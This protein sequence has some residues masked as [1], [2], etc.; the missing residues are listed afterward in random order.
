MSTVLMTSLS[1]SNADCFHALSVPFRSMACGIVMVWLAVATG[2]VR[3]ETEST[4]NLSHRFDARIRPLLDRYCV[5]CHSGHTPEG[6]LDLTAFGAIATLPQDV[7]IWQTI[8]QQ[9][10]EREMPPEDPQPSDPERSEL[11]TWIHDALAAIDW[12]GETGVTHVT[13]PRLSKAEY[14]NTVRDLLGLELHPERFLLDDSPGLSGFTNDRDGLFIPP[15]LAEQYFQAARYCFAAVGAVSAP[16]V[17]C[18][19]EAE[20]MLMTERSVRPSTLPDG[21]SGYVLK[22][23][24][25]QTLYDEFDAP[26]DGWYRF[27]FRGL[28]VGGETGLRLRI[29]NDPRA[30]FVL[31]ADEPREY[32]AEVLLRAGTHQ[33]TW[34]I[35][36]PPRLKA[37]ARAADQRARKRP[38]AAG[39]GPPLPDDAADQVATA[40]R[41]NAPQFP[42]PADAS[43]AVVVLIG[44]LNAALRSMQMRIEYMRLV[45]PDGDPKMLRGYFN[46]LPERTAAMAAIKADLAAAL[47]VDDDEIDRRLIAASGGLLEGNQEL[48]ARVLPAI[49]GVHDPAFLL[50]HK[51]ARFHS[52]PGSP[53][54]DWIAIDGPILP[55]EADTDRVLQLLEGQPDEVLG[56]FLPRAFR[57]PLRS[58]E[59]DRYAAI[60]QQAIDT[61][62]TG[63][64][65]AAVACSAALCSP[66]FLFRD[67]L[68]PRGDGS[69]LDDHQLA[70]RLSYFLWLSMPDAELV[71]L[72]D[73]GRLQDDAELR[74]QVRR[75]LAD[76][77]SRAFT[78]AFIE[79]WLGISGLGT[80]HV[81]DM[82]RFPEFTTAL[83]AAAKQEP[84]L[85]FEDMLRGR[86]SLRDFLDGRETFVN[87]D[88]AALYGIPAIHGD[89]LQRVSLIDDTRGGLL[90]MVAVLTASSTPNRTSPVLRGKWVLENLL[91]RHL[92]EPPADA[93]QLNDKAGSRGKTLREELAAHRRNASCAA[94]HDRIDPIGFGLEIFDAIGRYRAEEADRPVDTTGRLPGGADFSGP[95]EMRRLLADRHADEFV[96][97][98]IRRLAAFALGRA[99]EPEDEGL[100]LRLTAALQEAGY[101]ADKLVEELVLSEAF[102]SQPVAATAAISSP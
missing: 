16:P 70:S 55:H 17:S 51:P 74:R 13:L 6:D 45:T 23:Q 72:A 81:P 62:R 4:V 80:E 71:E 5:D 67:E 46:L 48:L 99:L 47:N 59:L 58:G 83:A 37:A 20:A 84:V 8:L 78:T 14:G 94:C 28:G 27:T 73:A 87:A 35:E 24:G 102:R 11:V 52:Q 92:A 64:E 96:T 53:G 29:D 19:H 33:M 42:V 82:R 100:V 39:Q 97:N 89:A 63:R 77:R 41:Q 60:A 25:Q 50:G 26:A 32:V 31:A 90:G 12:S 43:R 57:R 79:Q 22:G 38:R 91:G 54:I 95:A 40:S 61:G 15:A 18:R 34:N 49:D 1:R 98:V 36:L 69:R 75:M 44:R 65:A 3:A 9:V 21:S 10:E 2:T 88:L 86:G 30:D 56:R 66:H 76:R 85:L 101:R 93:G 68:A 7:R